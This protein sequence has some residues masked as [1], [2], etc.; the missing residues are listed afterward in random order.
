MHPKWKRNG[1]DNVWL[2]LWRAHSLHSIVYTESILCHSTVVWGLPCVVLKNLKPYQLSYT[3][4]LNPTQGSSSSELSWCVVDLFALPCLSTSLPSCWDMCRKHSRYVCTLIG[5][6]WPKDLMFVARFIAVL[7]SGLDSKS[8][9]FAVYDTLA[10][11]QTHSS[12]CMRSDD[13]TALAHT[14]GNKTCW[15]LWSAVVLQLY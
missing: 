14:R 11:L 9:F 4:R 7:A 6:A 1:K 10:A 2:E 5:R 3:T 8:I 12:T 13:F 15:G